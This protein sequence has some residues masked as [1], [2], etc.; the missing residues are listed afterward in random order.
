MGPLPLLPPPSGSPALTLCVIV[1][2]PAFDLR[3]GRKAISTVGFAPIIGRRNGD[4][5]C[6]GEWPSYGNKSRMGALG[7]YLTDRAAQMVRLRCVFCV[8]REKG[9]VAG[10]RYGEKIQVGPSSRCN[11]FAGAPSREVS[12]T[13][14]VAVR[15][16][17]RQGRYVTW[18]RRVGASSSMSQPRERRAHLRSRNQ[19]QKPKSPINCPR[20]IEERRC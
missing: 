3:V 9:R 17:L 7:R 6:I 2:V 20:R 15:P 11:L 5:S 14:A 13:V 1:G 19:L 4:T 8:A 18:T 16:R 10:N 12:M